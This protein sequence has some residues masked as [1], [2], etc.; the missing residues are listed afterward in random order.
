[1]S[2]NTNKLYPPYIEGSLPAFTEKKLILPYILN[3]GVSKELIA[4]YKLLVKKVTTNL[5]ITT[6]TSDPNYLEEYKNSNCVEFDLSSIED[7]KEG[8]Y[9]KFQLAFESLDENN[10]A[11]TGYYSTPAVAKYIASPKIEIINFDSEAMRV[12]GVYNSNNSKEYLYSYRFILKQND[13]K[14]IEDSKDIIFNSSY[15]DENNNAVLTY[16][17]NFQPSYGQKYYVIFEITTGNKYQTK[18]QSEV[19]QALPSIMPTSLFNLKAINNYD[20]GYIELAIEPLDG[21]FDLAIGEFKIGRS[22]SKDNFNSYEEILTFELLNEAPNKILYKDY[23]IEHGVEYRYAYQQYN[24]AYKNNDQGAI[25][26]RR[27]W[28][29][30]TKAKFEDLFLSDG[31]VSF[32][33]KFNP[34]ITSV[35]T[36]LQEAKI[37][38][39][40][41]QYPFI[42]RNGNVNY[43]EFPIS[44]LI[45]YLGD[46][47]EEFMKWS[48]EF[49]KTTNL[50]DQNIYQER[51][52]KFKVMDWLNN[53]QVKYFKSPS[54]GSYLVRLMNISFAPNDQLGRMLHTFSATAY[55]VG[56]NNSENLKKYNLIQSSNFIPST[57]LTFIREEVINSE[58]N[59]LIE[60][61]NILGLEFYVN[62]DNTNNVSINSEYDVKI[63][64]NLGTKIW[65]NDNQDLTD[66]I[67]KQEQIEYQEKTIFIPAYIQNY[68]SNVPYSYVAIKALNKTVHIVYKAK[69]T[70]SIAD[71]PFELVESVNIN[72]ATG[73]K[74]NQDL[75]IRQLTGL[76]AQEHDV[77]Q[78][79]E[80]QRFNGFAEN[81]KG[82]IA[83]CSFLSFYKNPDVAYPFNWDSQNF[84]ITING[85]VID[86]NDTRSYQLTNLDYITDL[87]IGPGIILECGYYLNHI[88][89]KE[90]GDKA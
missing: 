5:T 40:G 43:R 80:S 26:S 86:L 22:S 74:I 17:F 69:N 15:T 63:N 4:G 41:G 12:Q 76:Q 27:I 10:K 68:S 18:V 73:E 55:E 81:T 52:F 44:G 82:E 85:T 14:I 36:T 21:N 23:Y 51:Q 79:L 34:K 71:S 88:K 87:R 9:Y 32:K 67:K 65:L 13:D 39:L 19:V 58:E 33:V 1:M 54:E 45:S 70:I 11:I 28:S 75:Q 16:D 50:T 66:K 60:L 77:K 57:N 46:E 20:N 3:R 53:G 90:E 83:F 31:D 37:D 89:F 38:T 30:T 24:M 25:I 42:F 59:S 7:L 29:N 61:N 62:Q 35:K 48:P 84:K 6:I 56:E 64:E 78:T 2:I 49:Q 47:N 8:G 72:P